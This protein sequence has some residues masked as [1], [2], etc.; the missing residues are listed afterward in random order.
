MTRAVPDGLTTPDV[1]AWDDLVDR[2][3]ALD[4][5]YLSGGSAWDGQTSRYRTVEDVAIAQLISDLA[6]AAHPRLRDAL[7]ALLFRHPEYTLTARQVATSLPDESRRARSSHLTQATQPV[8]LKRGEI[9][10]GQ[11]GD[12]D[13]P[14]ASIAERRPARE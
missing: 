11:G 12:A 1:A 3:K 14:A 7:V 4:V 5:R 6:S 2:L 9:G 10:H 13:R 8:P